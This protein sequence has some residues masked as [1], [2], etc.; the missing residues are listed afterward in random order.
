MCTY[1]CLLHALYVQYVSTRGFI[2]T[3]NERVKDYGKQ[4]LWA[5]IGFGIG[6]LLIGYLTDVYTAY[7]GLKCGGKDY[8][9]TFLGMTVFGLVSAGVCSRLSI[10]HHT[11]PSIWSGMIEFH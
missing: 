3:G 10:P 1:L 11:I 2:F 5:S 8:L 7:L 4:R 9:F 6:G